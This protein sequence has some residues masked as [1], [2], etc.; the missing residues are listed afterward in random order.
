MNTQKA[1]SQAAEVELAETPD[2]K[3]IV[4]RIARD[5][6][7]LAFVELY[8]YFGPRL[9]S[10]LMNKGLNAATAEEVL[11]EAMLAVWNNAGRYNPDTAAVS[12][13]IFT[14]ARNKYIDRMRRESR[15]DAESSDFE[16]QAGDSENADEEAEQS[17]RDSAVRDA[18]AM[19]PEEQ[20][21]VIFLGFIQ[22]LSHSEIATT[23]GVPLGTVKSRM[24]LA[25]GRMRVELGEFSNEHA[26]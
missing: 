13:W 4:A 15:H 1:A 23:L 11:Q 22:G 10:F 5:R 16:M 14:I 12:T 6:D 24:R 8:N 21:V 3:S 20:Q 19:L 9:K 18:M 17:Q 26:T 25:F 2:T 7:K